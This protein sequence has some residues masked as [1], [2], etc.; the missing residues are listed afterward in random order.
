MVSINKNK[1]YIILSEIA[2]ISLFIMKYQRWNVFL[3]GLLII[4]FGITI[5]SEHKYVSMTRGETVIA[6]ILVVT[7]FMHFYGSKAIIMLADY[8]GLPDWASEQ[9]TAVI[10]GF[11][12]MAIGFPAACFWAKKI[13]PYIQILSGVFWKRIKEI[14]ILLG[15]YI[16]GIS[17]ILR[18]N[19][20]Y[21]DD[22]GRIIKGTPILG[23]YSRF[24][25][26]LMAGLF[27]SNR[28]LTDI[29]PLPQIIAVIIMALAGSILLEVFSEDDMINPLQTIALTPMAL[30]PWF[31]ACLSYKYDAPYMAMSVFV[32]I[33]PILYKEYNTKR[34]I[35]ITIISTIVMCTTYQAS[36]GIFPMMVTIVAL[37]MA[38]NTNDIMTAILYALKSAIGYMVG[39]IV[40]YV[41]VAEPVPSS[42]YAGTGIN[43][44]YFFS[45]LKRCVLRIIDDMTIIWAILVVV[46]FIS[47]IFV[48]LRTGMMTLSHKIPLVISTVILAAVLSFGAYLFLE[49]PI[50]S[51]RSLYSMGIVLAV[52]SCVIIG[53]RDCK[54]IPG[55]LAAI[56]LCW[57]FFSFAFT[58]GNA[59]SQQQQY[60]EFRKIV[61]A[62]D[63]AEL[64]TNL[65]NDKTE[66]KIRGNVGLAR[67]VR[68][69]SEQ[70]PVL[71]KNICILL[72]NSSWGPCTLLPYCELDTV[73]KE[74]S[75]TERKMEI[76]TSEFSVLKK[77]LYHTIYDGGDYIVVKLR[78]L[79]AEKEKQE[80]NEQD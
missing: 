66:L 67:S 39:L 28:F 79:E 11:G 58:Y 41:F 57:T 10:I 27:H 25:S 16:L 30:S 45:N 59:L 1:I 49:K 43:I 61:L 35:I 54:N 6:G 17:A 9:R 26:D 34:Y 15:I 75:S 65:E 40:F 52:M 4:S 60:E 46:I 24:F 77:S 68:K 50:V 22:I 36:S 21:I 32:S 51:S 33:L 53:N 18:G 14:V 8:F 48:L 44:K 31:L 37:I 19:I 72:Q 5:K 3:M 55:K 64:K 13:Y 73:Y 80:V 38:V 7:G 63:L 23:N 12:L 71:R 78:N 70:Y 74:E 56:M 62:T 20:N 47:F 2:W 29:S 76:D 42:E 69:I